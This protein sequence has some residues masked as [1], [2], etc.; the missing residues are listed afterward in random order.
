MTLNLSWLDDFQALAASGNFSRA[1]EE[2]HMTQPAFSRR[3]RALEE[4]LG[5]E[6]FD[7]SSQPAR[8]TAA[9][10]WLRQ[11]SE[12][13]QAHVAR[14]PMEARAIAEAN[15]RSLRIAATHALSFSFLPRWL[16][17]LELAAPMGPLQL[18]SDG[19]QKCEAL[20]LNGRVE[21]VL[22][23]GHPGVASA[24][25]EAGC[26]YVVVGQDQLLPVSARGRDGL[27][28]PLHRLK[29]DGSVAGEVLAYGL[30]S[31]LGRLLR[32]RKGQ[33]YLRIAAQAGMTA[34]LASVLRTMALDGL[35]MAWLPEILVKEDLEEG[36]LV[37]AAASDWALALEVRLYR[38]PGPVGPSAEQLWQAVNPSAAIAVAG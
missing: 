5:T 13:V 22:T 17:T 29:G 23:H 10:Q 9:G 33:A 35:G 4:W 27:P 36:R 25:D 18:D 14:L 28:L 8:L 37:P 7:R 20:L 15:A 34:Q 2:R 16:R 24:L 31:G 3:V 12:E 32:E 19:S 30:G 21:L 11:A 6:L 38:G 1:A 26:P